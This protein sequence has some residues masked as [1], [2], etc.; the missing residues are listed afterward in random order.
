MAKIGSGSRCVNACALRF[1]YFRTLHV[2]WDIDRIPL[3]KEERKLPVVLSR[4]EV[5][6]LFAAADGLKAQA[7]LMVLYGTGVRVSELAHLQVGDIDRDRRL[8]HI[9]CG[10]GSRDRYVMLPERLMPVLD[11]YLEAARPTSWLFP[12]AK[13]GQP[14]SNCGVKKVCQRAAGRAKI[15]KHVTPHTL[16]HSFAT[17]LLEAGADLRTIQVLLGHRS[18]RTTVL[19]LHVAPATKPGLVSPL[20]TLEVTTAPGCP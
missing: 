5:R 10:K 16:R 20:D 12:G 15:T 3:P 11:A 1:L 17:H 7:I 13:A 6:R 14:M 8:V 19:Y 9:R 18:L 4:E 2:D